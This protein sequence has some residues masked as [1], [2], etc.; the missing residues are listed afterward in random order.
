MSLPHPIEAILFDLDGTIL[1]TANDLG[2]ALNYLLA[3]Y[4]LPLVARKNYR[5]VASDGALGLLTLG[6]GDKLV[7]YNYD[8]LRAEFLDYYTNNIAEHTCLYEGVSELLAYIE[9]EGIPWGIVTNKPE[10]LT[11]KLLPHFTQLN[12]CSVMVAGDTLAERKPH[13][14]PLF[15]A[16]QQ[17][18][19]N[20]QN[21]LYIGDA[22]RDIEA[23]NNA[24]MYTVV[25]LWGYIMD[26]SICEQWQPD[27]QTKHPIEI[28]DLLK[29]K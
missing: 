13:P 12:K 20:P 9:Q 11:Q 17:I 16:C 19:V 10:G 27:A 26:K 28:I 7:E 8:E 4:N 14:A 2:A 5:P 18:Q 21:S 25:A 24:Q 22:P 6:F 23:G 15:H 1:D 29:M 3:K